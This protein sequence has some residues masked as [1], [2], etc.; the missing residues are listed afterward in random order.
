MNGF[1]RPAVERVLRAL[2]VP[3][4]RALLVAL[5]G[6]DG[7]GKTSLTDTFASRLESLGVDVAVLGVD[8][9]QNPQSVRFGGP[10]PGLH[11]YRNAIRFDAMFRELVRPLVAARSIDLRAPGIRTDRDDYDEIAYR[12]DQVDVV[13]LEGIFLLQDRFNASYDV[14]L[15]VDCP[16]DIAL[17]RAVSRNAEQLPEARLRHDYVTIYHA[18]QRYHF[19]IDRP[20]A[21]ADFVIDNGRT[22]H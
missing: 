21:R 9:W 3:R 19:E 2:A 11:F 8:P 17:A 22:V 10:D 18:A 16:F 14:R 20:V 5:S 13:L 4:P 6:I 1:L 15:W 7:S 12:Y